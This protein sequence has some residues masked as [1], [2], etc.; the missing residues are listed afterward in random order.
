MNKKI[1]N[2]V[3]TLMVIGAFA[4]VMYD[5]HDK[6]NN[7]EEFAKSVENYEV[8]DSDGEKLE[9]GSEKG[10]AIFNYELTDI[11]TEETYNMEQF[12][13]KPVFLLFWASWCPYCT[14]FSKVLQEISLERDDIEII[15]INVIES[16]S[17][18]K[19]PLE[20]VDRLG[21]TYINAHP[22]EEMFDVFHAESVP[23]SF[24]I[25]SDGVIVDSFVGGMT[26]EAISAKFD[27]VN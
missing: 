13:G 23:T 11:K 5:F 21:L 26:K 8:Y 22:Q 1:V 10:N 7:Q 24:L 15:G 14:E 18:E 25:N 9:Y 16:E 27:E 2:Y 17:G 4:F 6:S 20:F 3:I 19:D 12:K